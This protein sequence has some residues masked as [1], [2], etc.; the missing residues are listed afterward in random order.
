MEKSKI[1][2]KVVGFFVSVALAGIGGGLIVVNL[3]LL[4]S[5]SA[6]TWPFAG[7]KT[8]FA[9]NQNSPKEQQSD[10][11]ASADRWSMKPP[12][13]VVMSS[14]SVHKSGDSSY[15]YVTIDG[16]LAIESNWLGDHFWNFVPEPH[17]VE[18]AY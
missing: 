7:G 3:M 14:W 6:P 13:V 15:R 5:G 2:L 11:N 8:C 16:R 18:N 10:S 12:E 1:T 17:V 9:N 4:E